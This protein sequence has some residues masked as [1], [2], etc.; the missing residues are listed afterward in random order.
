MLA[1]AAGATALAAALNPTKADA[2]DV[3]RTEFHLA[4]R[5]L[6]VDR[7]APH[8]LGVAA[9]RLSR[10]SARLLRA[11]VVLEDGR[12]LTLDRALRRCR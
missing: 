10:G 5:R 2:A 3:A 4:G 11:L 7:R 9:R 12:E 6:R 8:T 1:G